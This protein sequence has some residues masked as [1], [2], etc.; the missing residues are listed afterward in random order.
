MVVDALTELLLH[1]PADRLRR[2]AD[3][4]RVTISRF[5]PLTNGAAAA[6]QLRI[7]QTCPPRIQ[8][9]EQ[10]AAYQSVRFNIFTTALAKATAMNALE[11]TADTAAAIRAACASAPLIHTAAAANGESDAATGAGD[12]DESSPASDAVDASDDEVDEKRCVS[13]SRACPV[14]ACGMRVPL[15][16]SCRACMRASCLRVAVWARRSF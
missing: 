2:G 15:P 13:C 6:L 12:D 14:R 3:I 16:R 1:I 7:I 4:H 5:P 8:T 10:L 11:S 9:M